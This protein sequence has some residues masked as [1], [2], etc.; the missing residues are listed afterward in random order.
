MIELSSV[1]V[2]KVTNEKIGQEIGKIFTDPSPL[3][4]I[5]ILIKE[6]LASDIFKIPEY[7]TS[8]RLKCDEKKLDGLL[9]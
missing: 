5:D 3:A 2:A 7:R 8:F 4:A 9:V 6:N 1:L